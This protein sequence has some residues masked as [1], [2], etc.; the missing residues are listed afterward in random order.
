MTRTDFYHVVT[1]IGIGLI[2]VAVSV[3]VVAYFYRPDQAAEVQVHTP[4]TTPAPARRAP[5]ED[6]PTMLPK[7]I[8]GTPPARAGMGPADTRPPAG[9]HRQRVGDETAVLWP[10]PAAREGQL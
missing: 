3:G 1:G 5:V 2:L 6:I 9:R 8:P 4:A 7:P 10:L